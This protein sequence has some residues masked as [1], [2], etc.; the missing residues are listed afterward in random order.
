[1]VLPDALAEAR[2]GPVT[3]CSKA[4]EPRG[5]ALKGESEMKGNT[6]V[7][8][9]VVD[10][11]A[12]VLPPASPSVK[13]QG[14]LRVLERAA[15]D[16]DFIAALTYRGTEALADYDLDARE[17]AALLSGDINWVEDHVGKLDGRLRTWFECRLQ[18]EIW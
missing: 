15:E 4:G 12:L 3:M 5:R 8:E 2:A 1:M 6:W 11:P 18:Q 14:I 10:T 7:H 16:D 9:G 17:Q 13:T